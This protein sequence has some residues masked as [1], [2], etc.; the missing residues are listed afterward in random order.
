M[1]KSLAPKTTSLR[2]A[3]PE[4]LHQHQVAASFVELRE[5]EEPAVGETEAE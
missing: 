4:V 1:K 5:Q 2:P 3:S